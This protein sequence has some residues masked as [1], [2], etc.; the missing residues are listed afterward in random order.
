M[1]D[2]RFS[3]GSIVNWRA[4]N[5]G[6]T[7]QHQTPEQNMLALSM[8][9]CGIISKHIEEHREKLVNQDVLNRLRD[10][11][12]NYRNRKKRKSKMLA[13]KKMVKILSLP[14]GA[15]C[16]TNVF[17]EVVDFAIRKISEMISGKVIRVGTKLR[18]VGRKGIHVVT[19][20]LKNGRFLIKGKPG[21]FS[22]SSI[23]SYV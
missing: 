5:K 13:V 19:M 22:V 23:E 11:I 15:C 14:E 3:C 18:M 6:I 7:Q 21:T 17:L 16:T 12:V 10:L 2:N 20:V 4:K 1:I 9:R 8:E